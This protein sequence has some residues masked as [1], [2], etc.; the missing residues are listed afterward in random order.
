MLHHRGVRAIDNQFERAIGLF[1][2][3]KSDR[4]GGRYIGI[5]R[6]DNFVP[7][8]NNRTL[9]KTEPAECGATDFGHQIRYSPRL[10]AARPFVRALRGC[11]F[12]W[13]WLAFLHAA[14][15]ARS[16]AAVESAVQKTGDIAASLLKWYD[17]YARA[18]PWRAPPGSARTD[19]Y[20]V[21]LS[22]I[23]L[24][25]TTVSAVIPYFE[26]FTARWPN[27]ET[28]AVADDAELMAA[29]AGLGYYARARN[30]L[31]C[32]RAVAQQHGGQFPATESGLRAL[33]GIGAYTAAA[34]A[35]IAFDERAVVV[36]ANVERVVARLFAISTPLPAAKSEIHRFADRITPTKRPGDFAQ[37]MMDLGATVCTVRKPACLACPSSELCRGHRL[38]IAESLPVKPVKAPKPHRT[39]TAYW[40]ESNDHVWLVKRPAKGMLGGMRALPDDGWNA[41][42]D[43]DSVPPVAAEWRTLNSSVEHVFTHF[44]LSL[45]LAVTSSPVQPEG[46]MAGQWWPVNSL[47]SAGLPTLFKK[48]ARL[49]SGQGRE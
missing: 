24:Q 48:A 36:D 5:A 21:W 22:E 43:G 11:C 42:Q 46:M 45:K 25:Q 37:A 9:H 33:P 28:L 40:I 8:A 23:M 17:Q 49:V 7:T 2:C 44:S 47:D 29:W 35:A 19:P 14:I 26:R 27:V 30:L 15:I 32:A 12:A 34:I 39:G 16:M 31:A 13:L 18:L 1:A 6:S 41:R 20:R 10:P 3:W 38:G 4:F